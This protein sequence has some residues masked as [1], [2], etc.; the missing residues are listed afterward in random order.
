MINNYKYL[1]KNKTK[2]ENILT[3]LS[4][5]GSN[6]EKTRWT[7]PLKKMYSEQGKFVNI[8]ENVSQCRGKYQHWGKY[9]SGQVK[10][11]NIK[12]NVCKAGEICKH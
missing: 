10:T 11:I 1:G 8:K 12:E 6:D 9:I 7:V 5:A 2:F 4:V 3:H